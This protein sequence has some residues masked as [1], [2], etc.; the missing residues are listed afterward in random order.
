MQEEMEAGDVPRSIL[1]KGFIPSTSANDLK[2]FFSVYGEVT[3]IDKQYMRPKATVTFKSPLSVKALLSNPPEKMNN[4][5]I[6]ITA[7]RERFFI[8]VSNMANFDQT[9]KKAKTE[10]LHKLFSEHCK[11]VSIDLRNGDL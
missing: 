3:D 11:V 8:R 10:D 2:V 1:V 5:R 6:T 7:N 4:K 9:Q